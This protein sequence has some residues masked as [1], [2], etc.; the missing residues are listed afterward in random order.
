MTYEYGIIIPATSK[1]NNWN[2]F[3]ECDLYDSIKSLQ[4]ANLD[5][6]KK[7]IKLYIYVDFDDDFFQNKCVFSFPYDYEIIT[8]KNIKKGNVVGMWNLMFEKAKDECKYFLQTGSDVLYLDTGF[9]EASKKTL[10]ENDNI[11]VV[12]YIEETRK[13]DPKKLF[14]QSF[15]SKKHYEFFK[16]YFPPELTNWYCDDWITFFYRTTHNDFQLNYRITNTGGK[17]RYSPNTQDAN[18]CEELIEFHTKRIKLKDTLEYPSITLGMPI[19]NRRE[20]LPLI[21]R[22]INNLNY[23]LSKIEFLI[24]DDSDKGKELFTNQTLHEFKTHFK[25][26]DVNYIKQ[27]E[28]KTIGEK[29]NFICKKAKH[30]LIAFMDSDDLYMPDYLKH[31]YDT[32]KKDNATLVGSNQMIFTYP[33]DGWK[34]TGIQCS[35]K[36]MIHEA[37]MMLTKKHFRSTGGF[38]KNS[39]GEG[40]KMIDNLNSTKVSLTDCSK[41]MVC[42]SHNGNT[43]GKETFK[44]AQDLNDN[45]S[46]GQYDKMI[47]M[48]CL[49]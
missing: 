48:G 25:L 33:L 36:R 27:S 47:I 22:N 19:W 44:K 5:V 1:N 28:K 20:F 30:K 10:I 34:M 3:E 11:G 12:G 23:D 8:D 46:I 49:V 41:I 29:R 39:Q 45:C 14:C 2:T 4:V 43:I 9:L 37:T 15:V 6:D 24:L 16:F 42:I 13:D 18:L 7:K 17:P 21:I 31:S 40:T 38:I 32:M 35:Q 26:L